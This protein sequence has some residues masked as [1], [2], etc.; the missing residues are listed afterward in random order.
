[1]KAQRDEVICVSLNYPAAKMELESGF[2]NFKFK[3]V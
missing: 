2:L 1:M 3:C